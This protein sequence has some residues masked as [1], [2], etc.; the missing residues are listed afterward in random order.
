MKTFD[1][2]TLRDP[3]IQAILSQEYGRFSDAEY[4]RRR[5]R[6]GEVMARQ[7]C[8]AL[9]LA[10]EQRVGSAVHWVTA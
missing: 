6:L 5:Q 2:P 4:A 7:G 1:H 9:L 3:A 8:D 10:G